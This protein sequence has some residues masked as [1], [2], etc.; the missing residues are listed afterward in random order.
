MIRIVDQDGFKIRVIPNNLNFKIKHYCFIVVNIPDSNIVR[1][2]PCDAVCVKCGAGESLFI[3][4]NCEQTLIDEFIDDPLSFSQDAADIFI[5]FENSKMSLV[6]NIKETQNVYELTPVSM[7]EN[8]EFFDMFQDSFDTVIKET[9]SKIEK[10][11]MAR[12]Y[13]VTCIR[14]TT[15]F[16]TLLEKFKGAVNGVK[17]SSD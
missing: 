17:I 1:L 11:G 3:G 7:F 12:G 15:P 8:G 2:T 14:S 5:D 6:N 16:E 4:K 13:K 10:V 9:H